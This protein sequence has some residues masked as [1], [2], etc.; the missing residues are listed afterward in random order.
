MVLS[1]EEKLLNADIETKCRT[2]LLQVK[3]APDGKV[4]ASNEKQKERYLRCNNQR[5]SQTQIL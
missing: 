4:Y 3:P 1:T 5:L 2:K